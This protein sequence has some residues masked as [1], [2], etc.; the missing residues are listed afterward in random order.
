MRT[1]EQ[2]AAEANAL[3]LP[4]AYVEAV[5][6]RDVVQVIRMTK[7]DCPERVD[8]PWFEGTHAECCQYLRT[9]TAGRRGT[10]LELMYKETGRLASYIL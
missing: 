7:G 9:H 3:G 8:G 5:A 6:G 10:T 4:P 2:L 1:R